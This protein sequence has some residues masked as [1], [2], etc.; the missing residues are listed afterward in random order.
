MKTVQ[1]L[2]QEVMSDQELKVKAVE[3]AKAG[4][5]EA[6]LREHDCGATL[7]EVS[8]FLKE[9]ANGDMP[10][11]AGELENAAGGECN[12]ITI[13]EAVGSIGGVFGLMCA[14]QALRSLIK[15]H[16]GQQKEGEGRLCNE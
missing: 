12:H 16:V 10:L 14:G 1:E 5:L 11:S 2:F 15:G 9:K 3:A 7:E 4:R 13:G 6:F 8:A